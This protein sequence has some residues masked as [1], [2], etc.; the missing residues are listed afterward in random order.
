MGGTPALNLD[1]IDV[2]TTRE[3]LKAAIAGEK[4]ERDIMYPE[5]VEVAKRQK[6]TAALPTFTYALKVEAVYAVLC[7]D[8]LD[9]PDKRAGKT[10]P[11]TSAGDRGNTLEELNILKCLVCGHGKSGFVS[12]S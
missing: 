7:Q 1:P 11:I 8:A 6:A 10:I 2:K 3:N 12:V 4:Y 5:F 9:H